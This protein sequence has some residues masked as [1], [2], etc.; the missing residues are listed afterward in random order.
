VHQLRDS[1]SQVEGGAGVSTVC[2]DMDRAGRPLRRCEEIAIVGI[3]SPHGDDQ[4]GWAVV[5]NLRH[6][7]PTSITTHTAHGGLDLLA[8]LDGQDTMI[9]VDAAAPS[10]SPGRV[11]IF[12]W[13]CDALAEC[14]PLSTHGPGLAEALRLADVLGHLPRQVRIYA[15]EAETIEPGAP[16]SRFAARSVDAVANAILDE[17][18]RIPD[19]Q[20]AIGGPS[21][22]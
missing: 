19:A 18:M 17:L 14:R 21:H 8:C 11:W 1:L 7:L 13:P 16:L 22:A 9:V 6:Q 10:G 5:E 12:E 15:I 3:G 20:G 4:I 2:E